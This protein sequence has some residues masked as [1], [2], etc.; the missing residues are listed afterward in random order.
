MAYRVVVDTSAVLATL[1]S[2]PVRPAIVTATRGAAILAAPSLPWEI[3]NALVSLV[4]RH[5]ATPEDARQAWRT[6]ARVPIRY[7]DV[8]GSVAIGIAVEAGLYAYDAYVIE[9]ARTARVPL[10]SLDRA[11]CRAAKAL[12]VELVEVAA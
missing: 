5:V 11:Q 12:G 1:V 10:L 3:G 2:E 8:D 4:R 7:V 9:A 6:F